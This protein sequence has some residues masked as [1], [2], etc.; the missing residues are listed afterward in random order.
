MM[1]VHLKKRLEVIALS[2]CVTLGLGQMGESPRVPVAQA[3]FI[4][5]SH[6]DHDDL[7]DILVLYG[8]GA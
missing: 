1:N 3:K 5:A 7:K 2:V 4:P 8:F 6:L